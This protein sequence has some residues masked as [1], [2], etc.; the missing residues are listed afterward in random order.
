MQCIPHLYKLMLR[1]FLLCLARI[2]CWQPVLP[3]T[4]RAFFRNVFYLTR[5]AV[6][7]GGAADAAQVTCACLGE[8]GPFFEAFCML[9]FVLLLLAGSLAGFGDLQDFGG[10][11]CSCKGLWPPPQTSLRMVKG[12]QERTWD[13]LDTNVPPVRKQ[14]YM[15]FSLTERPFMGDIFFLLMCFISPWRQHSTVTE[16]QDKR[17][18]IPVW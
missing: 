1:I 17:P 14:L 6:K 4:F 8:N 2:C 18:A 3:L 11:S 9:S 12:W 16:A 7:N 13:L 15:C 10:G 5:K